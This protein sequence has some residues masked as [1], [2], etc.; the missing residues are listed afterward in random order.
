[1]ISEDAVRV[2]SQM[3]AV[4]KESNIDR[5]MGNEHVSQLLSI[6]TERER[7]VVIQYFFNGI[8]RKDLAVELNV[9]FQMVSQIY[10]NALRKMREYELTERE[11]VK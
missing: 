1:M 3:K 6:L 5:W 8:S 10:Q 9:C 2:R 7:Y 4:Q 11:S